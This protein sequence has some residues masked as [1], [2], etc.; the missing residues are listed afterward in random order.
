M[1]TSYRSV[2]AP[3]AL[4]GK[5][6]WV[7]GATRGI[8]QATAV[9]LARAGA[10]VALNDIDDNAKE[11][12]RLIEDLGRPVSFHQGDVSSRASVEATV[13]AVAR[14]HGRLDCLVANAGISVPQSFLEITDEVM[15][16]TLDINLRGV[17]LCGQAAARQ[18]VRQ[19]EGG[20][21]VNISSIHAV[22]S[23]RGF[24]VYDAAKA[25]VM[26]LTATM[27]ADLAEHGITVNAIGPG[28]MLTPMNASAYD[29]PE[30]R[31]AVDA[32]LPLHRVGLPEEIC[33]MAAYLCSPAAGYITG[34]FILVDG[35]LILAH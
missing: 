6:A 20:Q 8:G 7:T 25:G 16:R 22:S 14:T 2:L 28:W 31:A 19:G 1:T 18:M 34:S 4:A 26:R 23:F 13:D 30:K 35:G 11:T 3:D 21:I 12:V 9:E 15:Q 10:A 29:T 27:A 33:G 32:S 24:A 17:I 5:V